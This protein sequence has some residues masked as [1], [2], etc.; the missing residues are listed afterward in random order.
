MISRKF[1]ITC[2]LPNCVGII[3]GTLVFVTETPE[4]SGEDFNT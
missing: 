2:R 1:Y 4:W 3:D